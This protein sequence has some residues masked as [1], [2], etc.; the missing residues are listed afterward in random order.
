MKTFFQANPKDL[1]ATDYLKMQ[2]PWQREQLEKMVLELETRKKIDHSD[3]RPLGNFRWSLWC[4]ADGKDAVN[5][6]CYL[7]PSAAD[8]LSP[9]ASSILHPSATATMP[10][11][12]AQPKRLVIVGESYR[13]GEDPSSSEKEPEVYA[14]LMDKI[15]AQAFLEVISAIRSGLPSAYYTALGNGSYSIHIERPDLAYGV[16]IRCTARW[17][18]S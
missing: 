11:A 7:A 4:R 18:V 10:I 15:Q 16:H 2:E 6:I 12:Q 14:S 17:T 9:L 5:H 3:A 8:D 1:L 13:P